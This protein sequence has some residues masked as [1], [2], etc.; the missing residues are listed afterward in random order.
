MSWFSAK[1]TRAQFEPVPKNSWTTKVTPKPTVNVNSTGKYYIPKPN[2]LVNNTFKVSL[3][4][5]GSFFKANKTRKRKT[6]RS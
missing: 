6:R 3:K 4:K 5:Q 2:P 1:R